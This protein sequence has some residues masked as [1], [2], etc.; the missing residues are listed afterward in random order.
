MDQN[1][2]RPRGYACYCREAVDELKTD[3]K[4]LKPIALRRNALAPELLNL[5]V[6]TDV[7]IGMKAWREETG[8][9]WDLNIAERP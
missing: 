7:H 4:P 1:E 6:L 5:Y 9:D 8:A 2:R 3:L